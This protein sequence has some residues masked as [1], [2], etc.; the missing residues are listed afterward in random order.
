MERLQ[1]AMTVLEQRLA[2]GESG[3]FTNED[4]R[5]VELLAYRYGRL[6]EDM[7]TR[8]LPAILRALGEDD[9]DMTTIDRLD[10]LERLGWL[11]TAQEW[12]E[13]SRMCNTL[14]ARPQITEECLTHLR[15]ALASSRRLMEILA[16][17]GE[18]ARHR[19]P[20]VRS[21]APRPCPGTPA[22]AI[23]APL[24]PSGLAAA[25]AFSGG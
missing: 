16:M 19:F 9:P 4:R 6:L 8:L 12:L 13:L 18:K 25:T 20:G 23:A 7:G 11:P 14:T 5:L 10:R 2:G 24:M 3:Q 1:N 22:S 15:R 17:L 21:A